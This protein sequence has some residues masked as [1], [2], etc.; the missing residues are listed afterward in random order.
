MDNNQLIEVVVSKLAS[1]DEKIDLKKTILD[2]VLNKI[3]SVDEKIGSIDKTLVAQHRSLEH[4][5][6]RT[7]LAEENI[8]LIR[9]ELK[10]VYKHIHMVEGALK[11]LGLISAVLGVLKLLSII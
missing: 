10:P 1:V 7:A 6:E 8:K 5:I 9:S 2:R 11:L 3:D 4:H